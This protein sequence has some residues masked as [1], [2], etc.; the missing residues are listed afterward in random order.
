MTV[1]DLKEIGGGK[2][3]VYLECCST[4]GYE[5]FMHVDDFDRGCDALLGKGVATAIMD[6]KHARK[7]A[8]ILL[9]EADECERLN[10]DNHTT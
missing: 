10:N 7:L 5:V 9:K 2:I 6:P 4:E 1:L 3:D 8:E